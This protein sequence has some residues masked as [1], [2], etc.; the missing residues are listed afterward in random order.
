[1]FALG[2]TRTWLLIALPAGLMLTGCAKKA[3]AP[4]VA[5]V[6]P[7]APVKYPVISP[8]FVD[9]LP[10]WGIREVTP[11]FPYAGFVAR[12][13]A[14]QEGTTITLAGSDIEG[15]EIALYR[16]KPQDNDF[17]DMEIESVETTKGDQVTKEEMPRA[18]LFQYPGRV[19]YIRLLYLVRVSESDHNMAI[20][21]SDDVD[22]LNALTKRA[23]AD[24][25][26]GCKN[27]LRAYCTWVPQGIA[28]Q[29]QRTPPR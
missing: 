11:I 15:Y 9:L 1:M 4:L 17:V 5:A 25:D 14:Q 10:E 28:V 27:E 22:Q 24:P 8:D 29:V 21:A 6:P 12:G 19:R 26:N 18:P 13:L 16:L 3:L 7:P 23:Q 2:E 20:L